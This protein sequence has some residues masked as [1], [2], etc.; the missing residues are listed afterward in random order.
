MGT[1]AA[2]LEMVRDRGYSVCYISS[3]KGS[4]GHW[5]EEQKWIDLWK[6]KFLFSLPML[7]EEE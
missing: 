7:E 5:K 1:R 3:N 4:I 6:A 2:K